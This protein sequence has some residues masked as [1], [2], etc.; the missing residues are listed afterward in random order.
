LSLPPLYPTVTSS[1][2]TLAVETVVVMPVLEVVDATKL[3]LLYR[4]WRSL[5][6]PKRTFSLPETVTTSAKTLAAETEVAPPVF[7]LA[8][9]PDP[10][11]S[12]MPLLASLISSLLE[13]LSPPLPLMLLPLLWTALEVTLPNAP[14][15]SP[16]LSLPS[17]MPLM[18]LTRPSLTVVVLVPS[19]SPTSLPLLPLSV[20]QPL[21]SLPLSLIAKLQTRL[22]A[23]RISEAPSSLLPKL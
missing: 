15:T 12:R 1:A 10:A 2:R 17:A 19:V 8:D 7:P 22:L 9:A 4:S 18:M 13:V 16:V 5:P 11:L 3:A 14:L 21:T 20:P 6:V 23:R